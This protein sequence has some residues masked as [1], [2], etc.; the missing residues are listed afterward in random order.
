MSLITIRSIDR[1]TSSESSS[2]CKFYLTPGIDLGEAKKT[3]LKLEFAQIFNTPYHIQASNC[4]IDFYENGSDKVAT[5]SHGYYDAGSLASE[6]ASKMTTAS[7][8]NTFLVTYATLTRRFTF[9]ANTMNFQMKLLTG[10]SAASSPWR[11]LGFLSSNGLAAVDSTIAMA[12]TP[13]FPVNLTLP[14]SWYVNIP[15]LGLR[16]QSTSS[17]QP[18][19]SL[20]LPMTSSSGFLSEYTKLLPAQELIAHERW[21]RN[22][23]VQWFTGDTELS[24]Q[25]SEWEI[26]FSVENK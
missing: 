8:V 1:H 19:Y 7:G 13:D 24:L 12:I 9:T 15:E 22:F 21:L 10:A 20:Y 25:N 23:S 6:I 3:T 2:N 11:E 5:L 17:T 4:V 18:I 26:V 14:M 16:S